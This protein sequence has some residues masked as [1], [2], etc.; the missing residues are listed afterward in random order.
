[1]DAISREEALKL[2]EEVRQENRHKWFSAARWQC[3]GCVSFTRG[4]LDKMCLRTPAGYNGC[5]LVNRRH[6]SR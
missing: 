5:T 2:C 4:D 6:A 3:W 1:M